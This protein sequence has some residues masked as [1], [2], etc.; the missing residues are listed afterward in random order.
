MYLIFDGG[1]ERV[2]LTQSNFD[3]MYTIFLQSQYSENPSCALYAHMDEGSPIA[4]L[5]TR[6][7]AA[8]QG[9]SN[10]VLSKNANPEKVSLKDNASDNA[11]S[12]SKEPTLSSDNIS[13]LS[14]DS[15]N[16]TDMNRD[17][18]NRD[19]N[20]CVFCMRRGEDLT[21]VAAH[22]FNLAEKK[23]I[24]GFEWLDVMAT[25]QFCHLYGVVNGL[26]LCPTCHM[27]FDANL[28]CLRREGGDYVVECSPGARF[29][30]FCTYNDHASQIHGNVIQQRRPELF[31]SERLVNHRY[32]RYLA[33]QATE[34][35]GDQYRCPACGHPYK[36]SSALVSHYMGVACRNEA[37][38]VFKVGK[39]KNVRNPDPE[40][41]QRSMAALLKAGKIKP[42]AVEAASDDIDNKLE[43]MTITK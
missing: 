41:D 29:D 8:R 43:N 6:N 16:Q 11:S 31:P 37:T 2:K 33:A 14:R 19:D 36:Q 28:I 13:N 21:L 10:N 20:R 40:R 17:C 3:D 32:E 23:K 39:F 24:D 25:L 26:C 34:R 1:K 4:A 38:E 27:L 22:V 35:C 5:T 7:L 18:L 30:R 9:T 12:V 15:H 42:G